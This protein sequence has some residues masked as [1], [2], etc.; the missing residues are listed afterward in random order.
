MSQPTTLRAV[1][2]LDLDWTAKLRTV[3]GPAYASFSGEHKKGTPR[4]SPNSAI[5]GDPPAGCPLG[6]S[7]EARFRRAKPDRSSSKCR[8]V[9]PQAGVMQ[10]GGG[11]SSVHQRKDNP[12]PL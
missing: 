1:C 7:L 9:A 3:A 4:N 2:Y 12:P 5:S 8:A 10:V 11:G 6:P